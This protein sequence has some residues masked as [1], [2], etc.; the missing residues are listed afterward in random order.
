MSAAAGKLSRRTEQDHLRVTSR[1]SRI[2]AQRQSHATSRRIGLRRAVLVDHS[3]DGGVAVASRAS[4]LTEG[5]E[6]LSGTLADL[7]RARLADGY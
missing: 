2:Y 7:K 4:G 3:V 5:Y 6:L 1:V